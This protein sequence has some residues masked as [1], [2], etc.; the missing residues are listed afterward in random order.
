MPNLD[1]QVPP[2]P[3]R[4]P[5][6]T[7]PGIKRDGTPLDS[8][9]WT[10]GQWV[11]FQRGRPKKMGGFR[12]M[13]RYAAGPIRTLL[14]DARAGAYTVHMFSKW[15]IESLQF[16]PTTGAGGGVGVRTPSSGFT[17]NDAYTWQAA[18]LVNAGGSPAY[19][20]CTAT[21]DALDISTDTAGPAYYGDITTI[22]AALA[23][24][25][26]ASVP[27]AVSGGCVA[28]GPFLF[29]YGSNGLIQNSNPNNISDSTGWVV[30]TGNNIFS[31]AANPID[32]KIVK[33]L[34][35]R[36]GAAAPAGLFWGLDQ[37][38]R[39]SFNPG[40]G[41]F[42]IWKYEPLGT[43]S[44]LAKNGIIEYDGV[45]YWAGVDRF[46]MYNGA[47]Q[48]LPNQMNLD[49]FF[50]NL[51]RASANLIWA[52]K[53]PRY[54]EIW[55]FYN[56]P[57]DNPGQPY[58]ANLAEPTR[59]VIYNVREG[60]WYD[61]VL[62]RGAGMEADI[63]PNPIMAGGEF[64][65][66]NAYYVPYTA[67]GTAFQIG[68]VVTG[69]T[70][71]ATGTVYRVVPGSL[72][73]QMAAGA[74]PFFTGETINGVPSSGVGT[75]TGTNTPQDIDTV[76]EHEFGTDAILDTGAVAI[77]SHITTQPISYPAGGPLAAAGAAQWA[78]TPGT[79]YQTRLT[80]V[81]PDFAARG[82]QTRLTGPMSIVVSGYA[83]ANS[84]D[85]NDGTFVVS[86]PYVFDNTV[87][88]VDIREQRRE[89][90]ITFSSNAYGG[91]FEMGRLS[92]TIEQ[93]DGRP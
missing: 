47:I 3:Q 64:D 49:W 4:I 22:T 52:M 31:N 84:Q 69:V 12:Y 68:D 93:G 21:P 25:T 20:C 27:F 78:G 83:Y 16:D 18:A 89:L 36:G 7:Q 88:F 1:Q 32:K 35:L 28:L 54:G 5:L 91:N 11:R 75:T 10:D 34:K 45:Y 81:E 51:N 74:Q 39:V 48:E 71:H 17:I 37:L 77:E 41:A 23:P 57:S 76:W 72:T 62:R 50:D 82:F 30:G 56:L 38:V 19:L 40:G 79:E 61:C 86:A 29:L 53:I 26:S 24:I 6:L 8:P 73:L 58:L 13:T 63:F 44:V 33:G 70:S 15:G 85:A 9:N 60:Y 66:K 59:A 46:Y 87:P 92:L 43:I 14:V 65:I 67:G 80:R 55:W 2:P 42:N 90:F